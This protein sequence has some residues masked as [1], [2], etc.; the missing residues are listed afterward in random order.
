[1]K[2]R[3]D[4]FAPLSRREYHPRLIAGNATCNFN[5]AIISRDDHY[6][7]KRHGGGSCEHLD[8]RSE[9]EKPGA[10]DSVMIM[11]LMSGPWKSKLKINLRWWANRP[12][13]WRWQNEAGAVRRHL[14]AHW[15]IR[16]CRQEIR[17][18]ASENRATPTSIPVMFIDRNAMPITI[19]RERWH[20]EM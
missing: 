11:T 6:E 16:P 13:S 7:I 18:R 5:E 4:D 8:M 3:T 12:C 1:M 10:S 2:W 14:A 20:G 19:F 17:R 15:C 9:L